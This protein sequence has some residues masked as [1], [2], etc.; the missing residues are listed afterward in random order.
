M[1]GVLT[2]LLFRR[3]WLF[4]V[5]VFLRLPCPRRATEFEL[6]QR[7]AYPAHPLAVRLPEA[8]TG[9][10]SVAENRCL[11]NRTGCRLLTPARDSWR[12]AHPGQ[13]DVASSSNC[14]CVSSAVQSPRTWRFQITVA[15]YAD[16]RRTMPS[17]STDCSL[18]QYFLCGSR[19]E[20]RGSR[21]VARAGLVRSSAMT[22]SG[23]DET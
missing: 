16:C 21:S 12:R 1:E 10:A 14:D 20:M 13:P 17:A 9:A 2:I 7:A 15:T 3:N 5:N 23:Q 8:G 4:C 19:R 18:R 6:S 22:P 11:A